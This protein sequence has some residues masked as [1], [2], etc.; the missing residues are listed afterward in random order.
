VRK[1]AE[2][3]GEF[4]FVGT[5]RQAADLIKEESERCGMHHVNE[6]WLGGM[7]TNFATIQ[8][9]VRRLKDL[10]KTAEGS[11]QGYTKKEALKLEHERAK[12]DKVLRGVKNMYRLPAMLFVVDC[13]KEKL[14]IDEARRLD[15]P[16]VAMVD[17][18]ID[19]DPITYPIPA[20]DDALRSI[21]LISYLVTEAVLEG[22][23]K[24]QKEQEA[25][26]QD[27]KPG[28]EGAP[29]RP[30]RHL[31]DRKPR[32]SP[33]R[34][35]PRRGGGGDRGGPRRGGDRPPPPRGSRPPGPRPPRPAPAAGPKPETKPAP[36]PG[37]EQA[38]AKEPPKE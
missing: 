18:N 16:V 35:E 34:G 5:K 1:T 7:L 4:L 8:K 20:N 19:P 29:G 13:K 9:S 24:Y 25:V 31:S 21:K 32:T 14:A 17:T 26:Q 33:G 28:T 36:R 11:Y 27:Q 22:R 3:G 10:E 23:A 38:P 12:M 15:I 37:S 2:A 6:R 30:V